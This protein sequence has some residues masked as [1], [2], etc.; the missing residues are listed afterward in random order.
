[1][2]TSQRKICEQMW[3]EKK[4]QPP[5]QTLVRVKKLVRARAFRPQTQVTSSLI[6][7]HCAPVPMPPAESMSWYKPKPGVGS[8][9]GTFG[10][11]ASVCLGC[12]VSTGRDCG[13][14]GFLP[15]KPSDTRM[16]WHRS[17]Q[18]CCQHGRC[19]FGSGH[20]RR[21]RGMGWGW[22]DKHEGWA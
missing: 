11:A 6:Q 19:A 17:L 22:A 16:A 13:G 3:K 14:S 9:L 20:Q 10:V 21:A 8:S 15:S 2:A 1:M 12:T 18:E 7:H 4:P 5:E